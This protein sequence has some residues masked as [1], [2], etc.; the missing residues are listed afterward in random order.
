MPFILHNPHT[1]LLSGTSDKT[2]WG[3]KR[4]CWDSNKSLW[5][6]EATTR[7]HFSQLNEVI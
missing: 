3:K 7:K 4:G 2:K 6:T 1:L 5:G